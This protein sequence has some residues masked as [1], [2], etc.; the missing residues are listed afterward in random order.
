MIINDFQ[1]FVDI[2]RGKKFNLFDFIRF[3]TFKYNLISL[4]QNCFPRVIC[5]FA[6]L[7]PTKAYGELSCPFDL[8]YYYN[9]DNLIKIL[10]NDFET[11]FDETNFDNEAQTFINY[12]LNINFVHDGKLSKEQF[13]NRYKKRIENFEYY[14]NNEKPLI[15]LFYA[16]SEIHRKQ[17][18]RIYEFIKNKRNGKFF[19]LIVAH[20]SDID[21]KNMPKN[22]ILVDNIDV[23][24]LE[25]EGPWIRMLRPNTRK[26]NKLANEIYT[27]VTNA[28]KQAIKES[29]NN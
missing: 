4:G 12:P 7:K 8:A 14:L 26:K 28:I 6:K 25:K 18:L 20:H 21:T 3:K 15:C 24:K 27:N 11:Y 1:D 23:F 29:C 19:R 5:T 16:E 17:I 9:I 13:I 22:L 2:L 10:E